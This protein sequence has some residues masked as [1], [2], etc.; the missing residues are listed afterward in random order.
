MIIM[1]FFIYIYSFYYIFNTDARGFHSQQSADAGVRMF[2]NLGKTRSLFP[3]V[4]GLH[5]F[6]RGISPTRC[7]CISTYIFSP[8]RFG[9]SQGS[10][11]HARAVTLR[12]G[13]PLSQNPEGEGGSVQQLA[14]GRLFGRCPHPGDS[15][16]QGGVSRPSWKSIHLLTLVF[17][18]PPSPSSKRSLARSRRSLFIALE[19]F[20][21]LN[22]FIIL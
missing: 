7:I 8:L 3:F 9:C 6:L 5:I 1:V 4:Q 20:I 13:P 2:N 15:P 11:D 14:R 18:V 12:P 21:D 22:N 10:A 19:P 17:L 16:S